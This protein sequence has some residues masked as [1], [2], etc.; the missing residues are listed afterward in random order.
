MHMVCFPELADRSYPTGRLQRCDG[1]HAGAV[2]PV[3]GQDRLET[4]S[5]RVDNYRV[6][7]VVGRSSIQ[8]RDPRGRW[9]W[10]QEAQNPE[11][12]LPLPHS[13]LLISRNADQ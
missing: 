2:R 11:S 7:D 5:A 4:V 12:D 6:P 9:R 3:V 10:E 8:F 13:Q 1:N